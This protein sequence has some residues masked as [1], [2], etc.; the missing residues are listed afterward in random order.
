MEQNEQFERFSNEKLD[1][2]RTRY[3]GEDLFRTWVPT[4]CQL[5]TQLGELNAVE[6][7][8]ETELIRQR[9]AAIKDY[10]DSEIPFLYGELSR[11][12]QSGQTAIIIL[13]VLFT[14]F[15]DAAPDMEDDAAERN[16]NRAVCNALAKILMHP[17]NRKFA[18]WLIRAFKHRR[19][20]NNDNKIVLPVTD[21]MSVKSPL[22]LMDEEA[23]AEIDTW[24]EDIGR[25]TLGI[26]RF[27]SIDWEM[28][29][30][31]WR[32]ICANPSIM[33]LLKRKQP[34]SKNN[35]WGKNLTL[36][37][38]V[39]GIMKGTPCGGRS[40]LEGTDFEISQAIGPNVRAYLAYHA[41]FGTNHTPLTQ[42]HHGK[43]KEVI[44]SVIA[45][46]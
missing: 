41:D 7:W 37:A 12:H 24:V 28:Y 46:R 26:R 15:C 43:I 33:Q 31:A 29:K 13:T 25:Q 2:L 1:S 11:R 17:Q 18:E 23:K 21:Y 3:R 44:A 39:L 19:Y 22:E 42:E 5:E 36:V 14:Q 27:L 16:P 35:T 8:S 40:V 32:E 20:D 9:L 4:L 34:N 10:R 6:V 30:Q 38:N 45:N